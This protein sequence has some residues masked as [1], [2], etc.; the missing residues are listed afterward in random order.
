MYNLFVI[1]LLAKEKKLY[2]FSI[3]NLNSTNEKKC[4][5]QEM[6]LN[7]FYEYN[8]LLNQKCEELTSFEK[9]GNLDSML[10]TRLQM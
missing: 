2:F 5:K 10:W 9:A 3:K 4:K 6:S 1:L 8:I 7:I